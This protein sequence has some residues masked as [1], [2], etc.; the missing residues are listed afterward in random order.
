MV[1]L[2]SK[3]RQALDSV[4]STRAKPKKQSHNE[5]TS[6]LS[7][8]DHCGRRR[9]CTDVYRQSSTLLSLSHSGFKVED[10]S[11]G[12]RRQAHGLSVSHGQLLTGKPVYFNFSTEMWHG[13]TVTLII[14]IF[15]SLFPGLS[16]LRQ[17][18]I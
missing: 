8:A 1:E 7:P 3:G 17:I 14:H 11:L 2:P 12:L 16:A 13:I 18:R 6:Y 4:P 9:V 5:M 10:K 15:L